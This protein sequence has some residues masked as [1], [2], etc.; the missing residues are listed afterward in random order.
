MLLK[1]ADRKDE[2]IAGLETLVAEAGGDRRKAL[3]REL[4]ILRA[5]IKGEKDSAYLIDFD[6]AQ[7]KNWVVIHDLRLELNDRVAQVDHLLINRFLEAYVLETKHFHA[8]IKITD[9]GEFLR[10]NNYRRTYEGMPSPL[11]QNERHLVVVRDAFQTIEMPTRLGIRLAPTLF[12]Y[13][14][15]SPEARIDR[16][17]SLDT[18]RVIKA[19]ALTGILDRRADE[20]SPLATLGSAAKLVSSDTL[21][22]IGR[23]LVRLHRPRPMDVQARYGGAAIARTPTDPTLGSGPL[24]SMVTAEG[25]VAAAP[26]RGAGSTEETAALPS[27][28]NC[29]GS[30]LAILYGNSYYFKCTDCNGNTPARVS[31]GKPA[32]KERLRKEGRNF[33]R[34]CSDCGTS[35]L[36]FVNPA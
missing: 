13:V 35:A 7:S 26:V 25:R 30:K 3:E 34:E 12:N 16:P 17:K 2:A 8:G 29:G 11:A 4:N 15:V 18:S 31:C 10:W 32:H 22:Q 14:L 27:C 36:Y 24:P 6:Y 20:M 23:Q 21:Q 1:V 9:Q 33:F 28:R 19:D 5:G